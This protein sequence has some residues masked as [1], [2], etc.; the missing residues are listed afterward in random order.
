MMTLSTRK[1]FL[2]RV[3]F[4]RAFNVEKNLDMWLKFFRTAVHQLF[5]DC[6]CLVLDKLLDVND[7]D[8]IN[9]LEAKAVDN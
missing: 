1:T 2:Q 6:K 9:F 4:E 3:G 8:A 5:V 7:R